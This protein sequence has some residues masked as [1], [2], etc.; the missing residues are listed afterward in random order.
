MRY[1]AGRAGAP[2]PLIV[3]AHGY[4]SSPGVYS[5]L[6]DSWSSAGYVVAAPSFPR[7]TAGGPLDEGDLVRQP[8]DLSFVITKV[9]A[10]AVPGGP[11]AG[12][13]DPSRVGVAGHSDGASTTDGVGYNSC[14]RDKR[15]IADAVM[16][17]DEHTFPGGALSVAGSPPL[18]VIQAD[19]DGFN[20]APLGLQVYHDG[21]TPKYLLWLVNA[22]HLE[23]F[24]TDLAH[25]AVVEAAT[26]GFFDRYL[27][28]RAGGVTAIRR[29]ASP[30]LATLTSG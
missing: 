19:H 3:F 27:K 20:P 2:F 1:P 12:I 22:Q 28:G 17:G 6:L 25:L 16:E 8:G 14:C 9:L 18:L 24:T 4:Q 26:T 30:G 11:L 7:A 13:V 23:P 21:R 29:A 5:S 10:L 15:V